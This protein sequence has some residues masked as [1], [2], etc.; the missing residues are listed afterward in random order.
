MP[1]ASRA[2]S[3]SGSWTSM[4][5]TLMR[6]S[7]SFSSIVRRRSTSEPLRPMT[8]PGRA[9]WMSICTFLSPIRSISMR[10]M[11]PRVNSPSSIRRIFE[12]STTWAA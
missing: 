5:L 2:A 3:V 4:T 10:V 8:T 7:V 6:R 12:S 11:A 9:V 1:R